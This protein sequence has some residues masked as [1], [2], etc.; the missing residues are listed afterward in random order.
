MWARRDKKFISNQ[1]SSDE[2][3]SRSVENICTEKAERK[4]ERES[5]GGGKVVG[6][7]FETSDYLLKCKFA[8][9]Y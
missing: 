3:K 6:K 4:E 2:R 5:F 8:T 1:V 7:Y 9:K